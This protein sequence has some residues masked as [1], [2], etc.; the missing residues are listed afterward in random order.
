[1][2]QI[3][4]LKQIEDCFRN[5][6]CQ[7]LGIPLNSHSKVRL[8]YP[9]DGAPDWKISEDVTFIRIQS[10]Q[11]PYGQQRDTTYLPLIEPTDE[12]RV[13]AYTRPHE[14]F[15]TLYGPNSY[16]NADRLRHMLFDSADFLSEH[17]LFMIPDVSLPNRRPE[18]F[19]SQWWERSDLQA[20][21]YEKIIRK[22]PAPYIQ[23]ADIQIITER[24][25][26]QDVNITTE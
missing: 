11:D 2:S 19:R 13:I 15:W 14:V 6:T 8:T 25:V 3:L 16:D 12:K 21:F 5:L 7:A 9:K 20:R 18:L 22:F 26:T 4:T 1:M 23:S 10:S 17:N 24:G